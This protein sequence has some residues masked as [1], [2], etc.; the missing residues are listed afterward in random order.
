MTGLKLMNETS[1]APPARSEAVLANQPSQHHAPAELRISQ[2]GGVAR[3]IVSNPARRNALTMVM[4]RQLIETFVQFNHDPAIRCIVLSGAGSQSFLSGAD[5]SEFE[6]YRSDAASEAEYLA[7]S[8]A[9]LLAPAHSSKP[10]IASIRGACVGGGLQLAVNCDVRIAARS[11][12]FMMPAARLGVG[13][14]Y[15][16]MAMFVSLLGRGP[17]ADLF[18][19]ARRV[20]AEEALELG[21]VTVVVADDELDDVVANYAGKVAGNAPLTLK[22]VKESI[23]QFTE[24]HSGADQTELRQLLDAC[25]SSQDAIEGRTAFLEKRPPSFQGR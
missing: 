7:T 11:A 6:K 15:P 10:V 24:Q 19:S 22:L 12:Y 4:K 13:Y 20:S 3:I 2:A 18:M 21:L 9:A 17:T 14:P 5:I 8:T 23:R 25:S 16:G 1:P